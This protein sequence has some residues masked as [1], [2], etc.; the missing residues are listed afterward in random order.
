M[1]RR[2]FIGLVGGAAAWPLA[3]AE[4]Q[5]V[6]RIGFLGPSPNAPFQ[7]F[8][9]GLREFGYVPGQTVAIESRFAAGD[10]DRL[11]ALAR[12]LVGLKVDV[13]VTWGPGVFAAR[14][15]TRTVPIIAATAGDLVALGLADSVGHPGGNVTGQTFFFDELIVKRIELTRLALPAMT[16][17]SL[18]VLKDAFAVPHILEAVEARAKALGVA[19]RPVEV[20]AASDCDSALS[21]A[22]LGSI[23]GLVVT[24]QS[25]FLSTPAAA[26]I[27]AAAA[28]RRLPAAGAP[29]LARNGGLVG[30][31]V[32][33]LPMW[34]RAA[35][36]VDKI[37]KGA[38]PSE[39]PIEQATK[40]VTIVN[41]KTANALGLDIPPDLLA[42]ATEVIE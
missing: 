36:F 18:L 3:A 37:L 12:E 11:T 28:E 24:D 22:S 21:A 13:L 29:S 27:A 42:A 15:V 26:A 10:G 16:S 17:V 5:R 38:K 19:V 6:P 33:F 7:A 31:G 23:D 30:Y 25:Q 2:E 40:F 9:A 20:A 14:R 32:D 4:Q 39:I 8:D 35:A 34:R 41:L 1:R